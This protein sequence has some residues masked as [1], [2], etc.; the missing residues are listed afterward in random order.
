[1]SALLWKLLD[2]YM[3]EMKDIGDEA[4]TSK[5]IRLSELLTHADL[6]DKIDIMS[7]RETLEYALNTV[8]EQSVVIYLTHHYSHD[9]VN[10][11]TGDKLYMVDQSLPT[12]DRIDAAVKRVQE[13]TPSTMVVIAPPG[14]KQGKGTACGGKGDGNKKGRGGRQTWQQQNG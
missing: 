11:F 13:M 4:A 7:L 6:M 9:V 5:D 3:E 8:H 2:E 12:H 1:M 10:A 14:A